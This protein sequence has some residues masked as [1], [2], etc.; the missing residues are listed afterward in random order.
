MDGWAKGSALPAGWEQLEGGIADKSITL[1]TL[2]QLVN[3]VRA[4]IRRADAS[5]GEI[6]ELIGRD[7]VVAAR[8]LQIAN[9][10]MYCRS[11]VVDTLAEAV[12]RVGLNLAS[13]LVLAL[14]LEQIFHAGSPRV[15]ERFKRLWQRSVGVADLSRALALRV[16]RSKANPDT[17]MLCGLFHQ[18]GALPVLY[19]LEDHPESWLVAGRAE[20]LLALGIQRFTGPLIEAWSL[21]ETIRTSLLDPQASICAGANSLLLRL[22]K[23]LYDGK[24]TDLAALPDSCLSR[25]GVSQG[26]LQAVLDELR[27]RVEGPSPSEPDGELYKCKLG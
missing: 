22:A 9:S 21:P 12:S 7:P 25:L 15:V 14:S 18:V 24:Q 4:Q 6:A 8:F 23:D 26:E 10:A 1:P 20:A 27:T 2:P 16:P 5:F 17:V 13:D 19:Y 3:D 11:R